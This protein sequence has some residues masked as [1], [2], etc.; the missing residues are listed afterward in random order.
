MKAGRQQLTAITP[1]AR[2][3]CSVLSRDINRN[4]TLTPVRNG[5]SGIQLD[6]HNDPRPDCNPNLR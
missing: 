5:R 6:N 4:G 3:F 1:N 2:N